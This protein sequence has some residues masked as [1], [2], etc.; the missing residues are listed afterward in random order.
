MN[1]TI[2]Q[3]LMMSAT[4]SMI[5]TAALAG[6]IGPRF[7]PGPT[8]QMDAQAAE[9]LLLGA[10]AQD[11]AALKDGANSLEAQVQNLSPGNSRY[12]FESKSCYG[13]VIFICQPRARL[14]ISVHT[15]QMGEL[16]S[17]SYTSSGTQDIATNRN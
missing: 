13:G 3:T 1:K 6:E 16:T 5:S 12:E 14:V 4:F 15:E 2:L 17:T 8:Q 11:L 9:V 10:S 7:E